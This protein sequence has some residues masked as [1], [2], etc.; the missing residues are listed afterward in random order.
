MLDTILIAAFALGLFA[1]IV[2]IRAILGL[3]WF[4]LL[5][6]CGLGSALFILAAIGKAMG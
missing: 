6:V 1:I 3:A 4:F 2:N 5:L